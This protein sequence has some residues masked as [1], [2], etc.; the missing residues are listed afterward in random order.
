MS[1]ANK[2]HQTLFFNE[3]AIALGTHSLAEASR[4]Y[5]AVLKAI[6]KTLKHQRIV[7]LPDFMT[8]CVKPH[9][10]RR[11]NDIKFPGGI[12]Y[13]PAINTLR[14]SATQKLKEYIKTL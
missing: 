6:T 9:A 7:Y 10:A 3:V 1:V 11:T 14:F 12:R 13:L 2:Q 5:Y 4:A 8:I